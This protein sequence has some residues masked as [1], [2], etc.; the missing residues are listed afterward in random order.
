MMTKLRERTAFILWFVIF[1]FIGLI[2]VE[3]GA[4]YSRTSKTGGGDSVGVINGENISAMDFQ[5]ALRNA[6]TAT[7]IV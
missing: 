1:A 4:D 2:V 6:A 3:W 7:R 5:A